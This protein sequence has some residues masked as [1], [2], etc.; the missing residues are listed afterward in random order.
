MAPSAK[1][2]IQSVGVGAAIPPQVTVTDPPGG[3]DAGA[4][5]RIADDGITDDGIADDGTADDGIAPP[6]SSRAT[7]SAVV[8]QALSF[9]VVSTALTE[10]K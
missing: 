9:P 8:E 7:A 1:K 5:L 6:K 4:E 3:T 10:A 2:P